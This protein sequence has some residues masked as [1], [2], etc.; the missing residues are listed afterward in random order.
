MNKLFHLDPCLAL[1]NHWT[2]NLVYPQCNYGQNTYSSSLGAVDT[3]V[4]RV[5]LQGGEKERECCRQVCG[6][7]KITRNHDSW[8]KIMTVHTVHQ[9][10]ITRK[11]ERAFNVTCFTLRMLWFVGICVYLQRDRRGQQL[12]WYRALLCLPEVRMGHWIQHLQSLP[13]TESHYPVRWVV[14]C[15]RMLYRC[16]MVY[17]SSWEYYAWNQ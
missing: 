2:V 4:T 8:C 16:F 14:G 9:E 10:K 3:V 1:N 11:Q 15:F 12:H 17:K 13:V 7:A 5:T 6:G